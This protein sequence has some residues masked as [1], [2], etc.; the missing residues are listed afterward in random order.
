[1]TFVCCDTK[2]SI[3]KTMK[4]STFK[5]TSANEIQDLRFSMAYHFDHESAIIHVNTKEFMS[6][7]WGVG[8]SPA[9]RGS[10]GET[11]KSP[12]AGGG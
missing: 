5:L 9:C 1:M 11:H 12:T 10:R 8:T 2:M 6:G 4:E 7:V 3:A